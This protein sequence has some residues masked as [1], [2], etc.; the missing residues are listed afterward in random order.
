MREYLWS[1]DEGN[2]C[3]TLSEEHLRE[4]GFSKTDLK[5]EPEIVITT[6]DDEDSVTGKSLVIYKKED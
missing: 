4:L 3:M 6:S 2:V 5:N 1:D